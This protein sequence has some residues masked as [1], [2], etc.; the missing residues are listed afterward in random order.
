MDAQLVLRQLRKDCQLGEV[1]HVWTE[2]A[3]VEAIAESGE[4][5]H[6]VIRKNQVR[7]FRDRFNKR[8]LRPDVSDLP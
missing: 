6:V 4:G 7:Q 2:E 1:T 8:F 5:P 3:F